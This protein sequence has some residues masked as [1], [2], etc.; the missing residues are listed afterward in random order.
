MKKILLIITFI[1]GGIGFA[2]AQQQNDCAG[3]SRTC[4]DGSQGI[5]T[6]MRG[7]APYEG[8]PPASYGLLCFVDGESPPPSFNNGNKKNTKEKDITAPTCSAGKILNKEKTACITDPCGGTLPPNT[9]T[10]RDLMA[11]WRAPIDGH[12]NQPTAQPQR[13]Y[14]LPAGPTTNFSAGTRITCK[15]QESPEE[16]K[17]NTCVAGEDA[18]RSRRI[19]ARLEENYW[20]QIYEKCERKIIN[21]VVVYPKAGKRVCGTANVFDALWGFLTH[22]KPY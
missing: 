8:E 12:V 14:P 17:F 20:N 11:S 22:R 2:E 6:R 7:T 18:I 4:S 21:G 9:M 13:A 1:V 5:C 10:I 19:G 3:Q 16:V 15:Y